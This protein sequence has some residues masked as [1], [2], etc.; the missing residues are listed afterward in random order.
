MEEVAT[1]SMDVI[2]IINNAKQ[3]KTKWKCHNVNDKI[4]KLF[5]RYNT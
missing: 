3:N 5:A 4:E 1:V 2:A